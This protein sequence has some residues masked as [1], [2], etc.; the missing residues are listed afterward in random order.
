MLHFIQTLVSRTAVPRWHPLRYPKLSI[1]KLPHSPTFVSYLRWFLLAHKCRSLDLFFSAVRG[2]LPTQWQSL[3]RSI[4]QWFLPRAT[5]PGRRSSPRRTHVCLFTDPAFIFLSSRFFHG[6]ALR[7]RQH[8]NG[9]LS[10]I[11]PTAGAKHQMLFRFRMSIVSGPAVNRRMLT[12]VWCCFGLGETAA[13][14]PSLRRACVQAG[15]KS[16][17]PV[18]PRILQ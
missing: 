16:W 12:L 3:G 17:S 14:T 13:W 11:F 18:V 7:C 4:L 2:S 1:L 10:L 9:Q 15:G 8:F 6:R 5:S